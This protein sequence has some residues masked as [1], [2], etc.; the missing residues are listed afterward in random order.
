MISVRSGF[1]LGFRFVKTIG[2]SFGWLHADA[3][4]S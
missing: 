2:G 4:H 1:K 3:G